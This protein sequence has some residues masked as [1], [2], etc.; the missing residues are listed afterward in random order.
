MQTEML[1]GDVIARLLTSDELDQEF[2]QAGDVVLSGYRTARGRMAERL[3]NILAGWVPGVFGIM[4][5]LACRHRPGGD[6]E[7]IKEAVAAEVARSAIADVAIWRW[8]R[9]A[10]AQWCCLVRFSPA[11]TMT[12]R[13]R[14]PGRSPMSRRSMTASALKAN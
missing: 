9:P 2:G 4:D 5:E 10:R 14:Q 8:T 7:A 11:A 3:R 6:G 13:S 1:H 12:S